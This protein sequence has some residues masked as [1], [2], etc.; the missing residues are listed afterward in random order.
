MKKFFHFFLFI[1][2]IVSAQSQHYFLLDKDTKLGIENANIDFNNGKGTHTD[3]KGLFK[4]PKNIE[5]I[6]ISIIGYES[7]ELNIKTKSDTIF[8]TRSTETLNE[9]SVIKEKRNYQQIFPQKGFN[10]LLMENWGSDG[11][12][13][14]SVVIKAIYIPNKSKDTTK[15]I[16]KII[17]H[18]TDYTS[19]SLGEK[20][21]HEKQKD[22]KYAPFKINLYTVDTIIGIPAKRIF[23]KDITV[24]LKEGEKHLSYELTVD[25]Q[26]NF[27]I[28]GVFIAISSFKK[29]YYE[30]IGFKTSP[31][32]RTIGISENS[33]FKVYKK[34]LV[35][36]DDEDPNA[37]WFRDQYMWDRNNTYY[38]G[39]EVY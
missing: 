34:S 14:V 29:D 31:G 3:Q 28:E 9:V 7:L 39:L 10:N 19:V 32:F 1:T 5:F 30:T 37:K 6:K 22:Q 4:V 2:C 17:L 16:S 24:Q 38:V 11:S 8:L 21:K 25:Q 20:K 27:P 15:I 23:E 18:P 35:F 36:F 13:I 26:L 12:T 33:K